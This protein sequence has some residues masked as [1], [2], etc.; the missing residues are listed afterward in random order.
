MI[1]PVRS[2]E[3]SLGSFLSGNPILFRAEDF[4]PFRIGLHDPL[5]HRSITY[6]QRWFRFK[7]IPLFHLR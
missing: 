3:G 6:G 4:L 1:I 7:G 2:S 5:S